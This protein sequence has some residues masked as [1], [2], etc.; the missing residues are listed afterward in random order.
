MRRPHLTRLTAAALEVAV[1]HIHRLVLAAETPEADRN[2]LR[3]ACRFI[4]DLIA[5]QKT[6]PKKGD[7]GAPTES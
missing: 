1:T 4:E 5:Y 6:G 7:R 3:R 2:E